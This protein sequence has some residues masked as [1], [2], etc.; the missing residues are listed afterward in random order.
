[1][2]D[3]HSG[4]YE[5][6]WFSLGGEVSTFWRNVLHHLQGRETEFLCSALKIKAICY[7]KML[8]TIC[9]ITWHHISENRHIYILLQ[10]M[11][12]QVLW[13]HFVANHYR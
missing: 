12:V 11:Q 2:Y 7:F 3:L 4:E 8:L 6:L 9:Q 5:R 10:T 13:T 1:M